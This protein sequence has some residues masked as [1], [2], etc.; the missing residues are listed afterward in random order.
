HAY[1][2]LLSVNEAAV[3]AQ[4]RLG[5]E[6]HR[7]IF[8]EDPKGFWLP[9]CGYFPGVDDFL[10]EEGIRFTVLE[11]HGITRADERP[12]YG[13]N[14][15]IYCPSG[16]AA[17]GRDPDSSRQVWSATEGYP[18]DY[19]YREFY[20]DIGWDADLNYIKPYIHRSGERM[21]TG[22]K[23]HRITGKGDQKEP[24]VPEWAERK[25]EIHAEHFV[26]ERTKEIDR[27]DA[28][29]DRKPLIVG[30]FDAELFGHWWFEGPLWLDHVIR[31]IAPREHTI[32]FVKLSEY[33]S[34]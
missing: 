17:F 14:A 10:A 13:I 4:V 5:A 6:H 22:I 25:A 20:R 21:D 33:L 19:D 26:E 27:L 15:P 12:R 16:V 29:M 7:Q 24:Y 34:E 31:K 11:T 30:P 18:G 3:R 32:R 9:E 8:R 2:P 23:Y 1:L 28:L